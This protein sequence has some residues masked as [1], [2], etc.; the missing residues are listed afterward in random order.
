M[1]HGVAAYAVETPSVAS[2]NQVNDGIPGIERW[3][4]KPCRNTHIGS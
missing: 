1:I 3:R 4:I 2:I